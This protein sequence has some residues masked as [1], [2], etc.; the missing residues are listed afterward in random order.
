VLF[1]TT[2]TQKLAPEQLAKQPLAGALLMLDVG[3]KGLAE[4]RYAG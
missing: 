2:A 3:V 1:V 4:V